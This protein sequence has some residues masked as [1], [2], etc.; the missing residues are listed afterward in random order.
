MS[1]ELTDEVQGAIEAAVDGV[2][3]RMLAAIKSAV[4]VMSEQGDA[5]PGAPFGPGPRQALDH[6]LA[7]AAE[8]G[9]AAHNVEPTIL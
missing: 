9:F 8:L 6:A 7:T 5:A 2:T 3:E 1:L 4:C